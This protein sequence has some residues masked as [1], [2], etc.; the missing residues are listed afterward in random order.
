[1]KPIL[2]GERYREILENQLKMHGFE[3]IWLPDN[4]E[5]DP[6]L[7]GHADLSIFCDNHHAV[8]AKH[9]TREDYIVNYLTFHDIAWKT[10]N[11]QG[12]DYPQDA[13][14]C[15]V[16]IGGKLYHK[17]SITDKSVRLLCPYRTVAINQG[18]ARCAVCCVDENSIITA[19]PGIARAASSNGADVLKIAGSGFVLQGFNE[20]FIGGSTFTDFRN[21]TVYFTGHLDR[22]DDKTRI[23]DFISAKGCRAVFLTQTRAFD[24][25]SAVVL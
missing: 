22:C 6:R 8:L 15:A 9:L 5:V 11:E 25:G 7:A 17:L 23:L 21:K 19:D 3:P 16:I 10:A 18:Y 4:P 12:A 14:L 13:A 24:I 1:M 20:G 2:I